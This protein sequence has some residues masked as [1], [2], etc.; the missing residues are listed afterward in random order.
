MKVRAIRIGYYG[1]E[2]VKEGQ[3]LFLKNEGEFSDRWMEKVDEDEDRPAPKRNS[4]PKPKTEPAPEEMSSG[5][6][7]V[8]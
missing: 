6:E 3:I 4:R 5:D 1:I 2:R 7:Q 8:L